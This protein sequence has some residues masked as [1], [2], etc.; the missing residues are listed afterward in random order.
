MFSA[1]T[2]SAT[3]AVKTVAPPA[4]VTDGAETVAPPSAV[5]SDGDDEMM[6]PVVAPVVLEF[7]PLNPIENQLV[8]DGGQMVAPV[9]P[10]APPV[11][12]PV[13]LEFVPLTEIENQLVDLAL[14]DGNDTE[15]I[16]QRDDIIVTRYDMQRLRP[17]IYVNDNVV[18]FIMTRFQLREFGKLGPGE[19][20]PECHFFTSH[21]YGK[22]FNPYANGVYRFEAV[23]RWTNPEKV[24]YDVL[25][26]MKL[27]LVISKE[28]WHWVA[29]IISL[30]PGNKY[31]D[32][33]DSLHSDDETASILLRWLEDEHKAKK[34]T[35]N[36]S[37]FKLTNRKD[38]P[39]Q[40]AGV[41]CALF[42]L[43]GVNCV[44][45]GADFNF[46]LAD[47]PMMRR[48]FAIDIINGNQL[49]HDE[50][51]GDE[52]YKLINKIPA[53][54]WIKGTQIEHLLD[55]KESFRAVLND[56]PLWCINFGTT[57]QFAAHKIN[58]KSSSPNTCGCVAY[59]IASG[60]LQAFSED[61]FSVNN[62]LSGSGIDRLINTGTDVY[63][64]S[65]SETAKLVNV[66]E[67]KAAKKSTL[68]HIDD[69]KLAVEKHFPNQKVFRLIWSQSYFR[70]EEIDAASEKYPEAVR[71]VIFNDDVLLS[72]DKF[73]DNILSFKNDKW[74]VHIIH[75]NAH[76][77]VTAMSPFGDAYIIESWARRFRGKETDKRPYIFCIPFSVKRSMIFKKYIQTSFNQEFIAELP[78]EIENCKAEEYQIIQQQFQAIQLVVTLCLM[79]KSKFQSYTFPIHILFTR[80]R[81]ALWPL[82]ALS[83]HAALLFPPSPL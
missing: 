78:K 44:S 61:S 70:S 45:Q 47:M 30:Q 64:N 79:F 39:Y 69:A 71:N 27:F 1:I 82:A 14:A 15:M 60:L 35:F 76:Y 55:F 24:G 33:C 75:L 11:V 43:A 54:V 29:V 74:T 20:T 3:V 12:G 65:L 6:T 50:N 4:T 9:V 73:V 7:V 22:L 80:H 62:I 31:I 28:N 13:V 67:G 25:D 72:F 48:R 23:Q 51:L 83:P 57:D 26:C 53:N 17:D 56:R 32:F 37:E 21:F 40:S 68:I 63:A 38:F 16:S 5:T 2:A 18:N 49:K 52:N 77:F 34:V 59:T 19:T 81:A 8:G 42:A 66:G 41:D 10:V 36:K 46:S 58:T